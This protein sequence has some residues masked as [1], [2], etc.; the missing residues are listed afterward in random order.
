MAKKAMDCLRGSISR[1]SRVDQN[2]TPT[3]PSQHD[4]G[5]KAGS[6]SAHDHHIE[7]ISHFAFEVAA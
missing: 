4:R 5:T 6:P 7:S 2:H 1:I 3:A